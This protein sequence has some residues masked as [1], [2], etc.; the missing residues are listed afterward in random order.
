[1]SAEKILAIIPARGG[2][3]GFPGK[4]THVLNGKP[5]IAWTIEAAQRA[6]YLDRVIL[7]S[8][9]EAII[10]TAQAYGCEVPF[11]RDA[12]LAQDETPMMDVVFDAIQRC[13]GY[14][15]TVLLQATSPLRQAED[16]DNA[17]RS[18]IQSGAPACVSV[19]SA[20][21]K[22]HWMYS[23][24]PD[25]TMQAFVT[26][27]NHA[28]RRQD[29]PTLYLTNGA[30]YIARTEWLLHQREFIS[31]ETIAYVMPIERSVDVDTEQDLVYL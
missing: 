17:I 25:N 10:H 4:N 27:D 8:D 20:R 24:A 7:S 6:S 26:E 1:M 13:S 30:I 15:W 18:C 21:E 11:V 31:P 16:I 3:K 14:E 2:S 28:T 23:L 5:L 19:C 29:L 9:C 22:P 12:K